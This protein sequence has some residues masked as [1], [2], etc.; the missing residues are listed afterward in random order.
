MAAKNT[1]C[2]ACGVVKPPS[3]F[4]GNN[5]VCNICRGERNVKKAN[6]SL[7]R[8][9]QRRLS[10]LRQ[11][12]K[13]YSG[14]SVTLDDLLDI[15]KKQKGMCAITGL[16]MHYTM[17]ESD[18][19]VSPDRIDNSQ[20]YIKSNVRLVCARANLM[21]SVL[22]DTHLLWWCRAVVNNLGN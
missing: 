3:G 2:S 20:G 1:A 7:E 18:L 4:S 12:H 15:Y 22:D 19:S 14:T 17:E 8:Y 16:P 5:K 6:G 21:Q 9:L 13:K 11:R 10:T